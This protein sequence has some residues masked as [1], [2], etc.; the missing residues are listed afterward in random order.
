MIEQYGESDIGVV[1]TQFL[2]IF[3][4][5]KGDSF[6]ISPDEPHAYI[7][8][9]LVEAMASSDN[10]VRGGLTPKFKDTKTLCEMLKYEFK[11][12]KVSQGQAVNHGTFYQTGFQEFSVHHVR[13]EATV[14]FNTVAIGIVMQGNGSAVFTIDGE[15]LSMELANST[16]YMF[17][18]GTVKVTSDS[19]NFSMFYCECDVSKIG[20]AHV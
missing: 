8:G 9:D 18:P 10:V 6:V 12:R 4:L 7:S 11:E 3:N 19:D 17:V 13:G 16:A 2:N 5:Q 20:R 1:F 14:S 15:E